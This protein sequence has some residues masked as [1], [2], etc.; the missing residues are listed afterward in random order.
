M[1]GPF[2]SRASKTVLPDCTK[3]LAKHNLL[4]ELLDEFASRRLSATF[5]A[6]TWA[7]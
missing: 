1:G 5:A 2:A 6:H 3:G 7:N 4:D